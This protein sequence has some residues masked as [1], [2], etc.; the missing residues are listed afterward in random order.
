M[1]LIGIASAVLG[2]A[3]AALLGKS[4]LQQAQAE[5]SQILTDLKQQLSEQSA[6]GLVL[7]SQVA[8]KTELLAKAEQGIEDRD[9][10]LAAAQQ[11]QSGLSAQMVSKPVDLCEASLNKSKK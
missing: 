2:A 3:V 4:R 6:Q 8:N 10:A 11:Q 5:H 1:L 7:E 9:Q